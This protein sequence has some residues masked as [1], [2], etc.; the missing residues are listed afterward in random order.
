MPANG[1]VSSL[2]ER[3]PALPAPGPYEPAPSE[4]EARVMVEERDTNQ[5][6]LRMMYRPGLDPSPTRRSARR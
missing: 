3:F 4:I 2:F 1:E 5:S 6:H